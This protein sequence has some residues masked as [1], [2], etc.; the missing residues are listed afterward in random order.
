MQSSLKKRSAFLNS[1][2]SKIKDED[3]CSNSPS[4]SPNKAQTPRD[5]PD[6]KGPIKP[7]DGLSSGEDNIYVNLAA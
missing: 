4:A 6:S 7:S 2:L 3:N 5:A 1:F